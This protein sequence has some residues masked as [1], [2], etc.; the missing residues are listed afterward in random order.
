MFPLFFVS[1]ITLHIFYNALYVVGAQIFE[2]G[3]RKE[4]RIQTGWNFIK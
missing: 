3:G 2:E 1:T 4:A